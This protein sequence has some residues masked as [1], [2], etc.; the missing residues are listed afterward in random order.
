VE[1]ASVGGLEGDVGLYVRR[2]FGA[3]DGT[4]EGTACGTELGGD[5]GSNVGSI[6]G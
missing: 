4:D 1:G 3:T 2:S 6:E 5:E